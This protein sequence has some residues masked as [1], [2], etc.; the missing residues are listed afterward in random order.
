MIYVLPG[1]RLRV[2]HAPPEAGAISSPI[3]QTGKLRLG[4]VISHKCRAGTQT[5][6]YRVP[7]GIL[8]ALI[9][10]L[11]LNMGQKFAEKKISHIW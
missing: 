1:F 8:L 3:E 6:V 4:C 10:T 11:Y 5:Q 2:I 9:F 7:N